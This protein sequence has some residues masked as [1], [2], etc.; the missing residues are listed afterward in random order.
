M[1]QIGG[2]GDAEVSLDAVFTCKKPPVAQLRPDLPQYLPGGRGFLQGDYEEQKEQA[3]ETET[4]M[5]TT[6]SHWVRTD[7]TGKKN[8]HYNYLK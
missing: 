8:K 7:Q 3:S 6:S 1:F 4:E 5:D 2:S